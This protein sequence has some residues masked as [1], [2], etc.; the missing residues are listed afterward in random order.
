MA[1]TD[2]RIERLTRWALALA[3]SGVLWSGV[4][5]APGEAQ[6]QGAAPAALP[7]AVGTF[8]YWGGLIFS[9]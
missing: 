8:T 5:A 6:A 4:A 1:H 7:K 2:G 3:A 9:E